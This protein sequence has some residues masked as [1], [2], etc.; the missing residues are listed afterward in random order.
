MDYSG[1]PRQSHIRYIP[2]VC[3]CL[4]SPLQLIAHRRRGKRGGSPRMVARLA[5]RRRGGDW[6]SSDNNRYIDALMPLLSIFKLSM[7]QRRRE[8]RIDGVLLPD[9]PTPN[10]ALPE[11]AGVIIV[12]NVTDPATD[13]RRAQLGLSN[14]TART[15]TALNPISDLPTTTAQASNQPGTSAMNEGQQMQVVSLWYRSQS[16]GSH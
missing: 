6:P 1:R 2:E 3:P 12:K 10:R 15:T 9:T 13:R 5:W 7:Q 16:T 8:T 14:P 11:G 4:P